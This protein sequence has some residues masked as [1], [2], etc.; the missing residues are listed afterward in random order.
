M[1]DTLAADVVEITV[2]VLETVVETAVAPVR[3]VR[4]II[5]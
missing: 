3:D 2:G 4:R 5:V 1:I